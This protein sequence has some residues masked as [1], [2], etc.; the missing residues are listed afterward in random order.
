MTNKRTTV[1][2]G[3][4]SEMISDVS[5]TSAKPLG[6]EALDTP[7]PLR[8]RSRSD[9]PNADGVSR[10]AGGASRKGPEPDRIARIKALCGQFH[11]NATELVLVAYRA[12]RELMA[13]RDETPY[14][15][16]EKRFDTELTFITKRH[17][18]NFIAVAR[19]F[20]SEAELS[21]FTLTQALDAARRSPRNAPSG[22]RPAPRD[23]AQSYLRKLAAF[24][25]Y[26][27]R[28]E[29][30]EIGPRLAAQG[31]QEAIEHWTAILQ[32]GDQAIAQLERPRKGVQARGGTCWAALAEGV[33]RSAG[34]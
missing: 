11:K 34:Y 25:G 32:A 3:L 30:G 19:A 9:P 7:R 24:R 23:P 2:A 18:N 17:A 10:A 22:A 20:K 13:L 28:T 27:E 5:D 15:Q 26:L 31:C 12:G 1:E 29:L 14:A 16:W 33:R 6:P 8:G 21:G 4:Q